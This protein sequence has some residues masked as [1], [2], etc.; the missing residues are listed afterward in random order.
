MSNQ[1]LRCVKKPLICA[2]ASVTANIAPS[3][4]FHISEGG[5]IPINN[6]QNLSILENKISIGS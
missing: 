4:V 5:L 1:F 3:K 6:Q 2:F